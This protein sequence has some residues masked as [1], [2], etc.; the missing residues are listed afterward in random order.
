MEGKA[1]MAKRY[2][3]RVVSLP[4]R[5]VSLL[6]TVLF[7]AL[8]AGQTQAADPKQKTFASP[9]EA[10]KAL[11]AA[12]KAG[13]TKALSAL[14]G[15]KGKELVFSGDPVADK[16]GREQFVALYEQKQKLEEAGA[17]KM[18]LVVGNEGWPFPVPVV[19]KQGSWRFDAAEGKQELLARRIGRNEL[20][21]IQVCLAYVDAQREYALKDRDS[22]GVLTYAQ[23]FR[24]SPGKKDGLYWQ[25]KE[26]EKPSP[27][28][29]FAAAA[30]K[31]GYAAAKKAG[32]PTPYHGYYYRILKAQGKDAPGGAYDYVVKG[33]MLGGFA[34]VA[35]PAQYGASGIMSFIV[36]HDGVVYQKD[37]GKN[38]EKTAQAMKRFNPDSTW[39]KV[40]KVMP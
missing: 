15:P 33:K 26:G 13:D 7:I 14:F 39:K 19:K 3:K 36:N 1:M 27:L 18:I 34:L 30:Q 21:A 24:S 12:S 35:Y 10:V 8:A 20:S 22:D 38:T 25:V 37:L 2:G 17:D 32:K 28:G 29:P 11:V 5:F 16:T 40:E 23:K 9:E 4:K 6:I 31:E